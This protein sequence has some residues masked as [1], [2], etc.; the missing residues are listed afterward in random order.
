MIKEN[1]HPVW[2]L[3]LNRQ[4]H[5]YQNRNA[6]HRQ[7]QSNTSTHSTHTQNN[8]YTHAHHTHMQHNNNLQTQ[9]INYKWYKKISKSHHDWYQEPGCLTFL[10]F[11]IVLD[12]FHIGL[13]KKIILQ[14]WLISIPGWHNC[15]CK[16][17]KFTN[18]LLEVK[19][20]QQ[21]GRI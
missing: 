2:T 6:M 8:I 13:S 7:R 14:I 11:N 10:G 9:I 3:A 21:G 1:K 20:G 4:M 16:N 18:T 19:P 15:L 12:T 17:I 5:T